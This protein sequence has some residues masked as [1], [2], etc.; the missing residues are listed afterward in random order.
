MIQVN[1][2]YDAYDVCLGI[3]KIIWKKRPYENM[4]N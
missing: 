2:T 3:K 1:Y 4:L